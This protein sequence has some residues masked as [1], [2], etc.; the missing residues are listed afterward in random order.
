MKW[1][2]R[3]GLICGQ[4]VLAA[5][6]AGSG[7][8]CAGSKSSK[9]VL[10]YESVGQAPC[11]PLGFSVYTAGLGYT[12]ARGMTYELDNAREVD[13]A[14]SGVAQIPV[15]AAADSHGNP[16]AQ[17]ALLARANQTVLPLAL[18]LATQL[19]GYMTRAGSASAMFNFQQQVMVQGNSQ[20]MYLVWQEIVD[21]SGRPRY[22]NVQ[23][24]P[25][26]PNFVY[27][28]YLP[29]AVDATLP[30]GFSAWSAAALTGNQVGGALPPPG[31]LQWQQVNQQLQPVT[32]A[33]VFSLGGAFD[34]PTVNP[35]AN[36][37]TPGCQSSNG[38]VLCDPD[39]GLKCLI[40]HAG[41]A[42]CPVVPINGFTDF[43]SLENAA[44]A[45]GGYL[46][47]VRSLR[48]V[49]TSSTNAQGQT[50]Q[51]AQVA[52][53]VTSRVWMQQ[54]V[55]NCQP[56]FEP[57]SWPWAFGLQ[58]ISPAGGAVF[59][60]SNPVIPSGWDN[61]GGSVTNGETL[62]GG[63]LQTE[64]GDAQGN[65]PTIAG[66]ELY[67]SLKPLRHG[68]QPWQ[69][70]IPICYF[71]VPNGTQY[72]I[73]TQNNGQ[74]TWG[75]F[76]NYGAPYIVNYSGV[77]SVTAGTA[78]G[79]TFTNSGNIGYQVLSVV[80]RYWVTPDGNY[81]LVGEQTA[82][83]QIPQQPYSKSVSLPMGAEPTAYSD[84]IIDPF[85][86]SQI[87]DYLDDTVNGLPAAAYPYVAPIV[88][89]P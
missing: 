63:V 88:E 1:I 39:Y 42:G 58:C 87:Y 44:G 53:D 22:G 36:A 81:F 29:Q 71:F 37:T 89:Q 49:Y 25:S 28:V 68:V 69:T 73:Y 2:V 85:R 9:T 4:L 35:G 45:S 48:P 5:L 50:V 86:T 33:Q 54:S 51:T 74:V 56:A 41:D 52:V 61:T 78:S 12:A 79:G 76:G 16:L 80:D 32:A 31:S 62:P 21:A 40:N 10:V 11:Y 38:Q 7:V 64:Q 70:V 8:A 55:M 60:F 3:D 43:I 82:T 14:A 66:A 47:Y 24:I 17:D 72:Q 83:P 18:A 65:C 34:A 27:G 23:L 30:A 19:S 59:L 13:A 77:A 67:Y 6:L 84:M 15:I 46:D 57:N 20:P 75:Y 26:A